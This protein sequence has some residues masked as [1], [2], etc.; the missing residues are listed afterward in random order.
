MPLGD[1]IGRFLPAGAAAVQAP[2]A[3]SGLRPPEKLLP[4]IQQDYCTGCSRCVEA[5]DHACLAMVWDFA[6]LQRAND[7]GSEGNC[8]AVCPSGV[9]TMQWVPLTDGDPEHG[10]WRGPPPGT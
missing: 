4:V 9:I 3:R 8:A 2:A 7:C 1:W 10:Q 5:C 6:T